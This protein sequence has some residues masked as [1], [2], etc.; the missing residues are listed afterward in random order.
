MTI[1]MPAVLLRWPRMTSVLCTAT[2]HYSLLLLAIWLSHTPNTPWQHNGIRPSIL[3]VS[4]IGPASA[5]PDLLPARTN[6]N[7]MVAATPLPAK[8]VPER[9][10][11]A[12]ARQT[13]QPTALPTPTSSSTVKAAPAQEASPAQ[14]VKATAN[15]GSHDSKDNAI[16]HTTH[17]ATGSTSND[18]QRTQA[19]QA[20]QATHQ[21]STAQ[22]RQAQPDYAY[23]PPPDYPIALR[24]NNISGIVHMQVLV[25]IDGSPREITVHKSSGYRLMDEAAVRAVR[26][27]RFIPALDN[28][29]A[30]TGWVEFPIRFSLTN[31]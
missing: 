23:N 12:A 6:V 27:W 13:A 21:T 8:Q 22:N 4:L 28:G 25:Q 17:G 5:V 31:S 1:T 9:T 29:R 24:E 11:K 26:R 7:T 3:E 18:V 15:T 16:D 14:P 20:A 30:S 19:A 10:Q 2:L